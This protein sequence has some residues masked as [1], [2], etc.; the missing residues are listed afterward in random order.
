[1]VELIAHRAGNTEVDLDSVRH[2]DVWL[3]LDV[4]L[5]RDRLVVRHAKRI[6]FTSR[7]WERWYLLP[8][9]VTFPTL[10]EMLQCIGDDTPLWI[11]CKGV[12]PR[13]ARRAVGAAGPGRQVTVSTKSWWMLA[14]VAGRPRVRT[15]RSAGNRL[16]LLAMRFLPSRVPLDGVVVHSRLL[17]ADVAAALQHRFGRLYS[18]SIPD[19][20]TARDLIGHGLDGLIVDDPGLLAE[21]AEAA[22]EGDQLGGDDTGSG[23]TGEGE[24]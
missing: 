22:V 9:G 5:D 16:E 3:E 11:D 23:E 1:M 17:T 24:R 6:W 20:E 4:H 18:W 13:L 2:L 12:T 14:P 8:R 19:A 15:I 21:L 7:F 10:D